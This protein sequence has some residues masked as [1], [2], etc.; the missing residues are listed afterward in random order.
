VAAPAAGVGRSTAA[1][2]LA[3]AAEDAAESSV[4]LVPEQWASRIH[5]LHASGELERAAGELREFRR[6]HPDADAYLSQELRPWA[7]TVDAEPSE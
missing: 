6:L 7:A 2:S 3:G 4:A 1:D 5:E